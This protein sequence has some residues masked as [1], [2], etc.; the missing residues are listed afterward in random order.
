MQ[1][2]NYGVG[3]SAVDQNFSGVGMAPYLMRIPIETLAAGVDISG[4]LLAQAPAGYTLTILKADLFSHGSPVG[5]DD[6]NK[7]TVVLKNGTNAIVTKEFDADP[8]FPE[9]EAAA[10]LGTLSAT[11]Q[12]ILAGA[13]LSLYVTNGATANPPAC[14]LQLLVCLDQA[15]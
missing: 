13:Y 1:P 12:K 11:Y 2:E 3:Q 5:I 15:F 10:S 8:A 14:T 9:A 4:R 7:C 6:A